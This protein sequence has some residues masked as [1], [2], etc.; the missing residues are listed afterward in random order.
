MSNDLYPFQPEP[1][2]PLTR[3]P[4]AA[5]L[6]GVFLGC[7]WTWIIGMVFPALLLRD[8]GLYGWFVFAT[9]NVL[10]A[11]AMGLVPLPSLPRLSAQSWANQAENSRSLS[12]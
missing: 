3:G 6:W 1:G 11:A 5:L 12:E 2:E 10:G 9:P 4:V 7:S 8:Y